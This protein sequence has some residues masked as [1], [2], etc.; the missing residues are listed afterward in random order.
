MFRQII[1]AP[2]QRDFQRILWRDNPQEQVQEYR[3]NTVTYGTGPATFLSVKV[4]LQLA[5]DEGHQYPLAAKAIRDFYVDDI[6]TGMNLRKWTTNDPELLKSLSKDQIEARFLEL[7]E[8]DTIKTLGI[9]WH[10]QGDQFQYRVKP[11]SP[12]KIT[13]RTIL[14]DVASIFDPIGWLA[15]AVLKAKLL[16][17][18]LWKEDIS[19]DSAIPKEIEEDWVEFMDMLPKVQ[20]INIKRFINYAPGAEVQLHG[21]ADSSEKAYGAVVYSRIVCKDSITI[22]LLAAKTRVTPL[23]TKVSLPRLELCAAVLLAE[24][25]NSVKMALQIPD[26]SMHAWSDSQIALSWIAKDPSEW[27]TYI[28]NRVAR[29]LDYTSREMWKHVISEENPADLASRGICPS[30]LK[31]SKI[32]WL[33]PSWLEKAGNNVPPTT[34]V[35]LICIPLGTLQYE[36]KSTHAESSIDALKLDVLTK[37][38]T[39]AKT[40][41]ITAYILRF[42]NN[43][44][45]LGRCSGPLTLSEIKISERTLIKMLQSQHYAQEI[46]RL[47]KKQP[48]Q[49]G[50]KILSLSP[51]LDGRGILRVGGRLQNSELL[52]GTKHPVLIPHKSHLAALILLE[53]HI[54]TYHGGNSLTLNYSRAKYWIPNA[55]TTVK[56]VVSKCITCFRYKRHLTEQVMG[57]LPQDRVTPSPCI[58]TE[59]FMGAFNR[60]ISR[61]GKPVSIYS[62]NGTNLVGAKNLLDKETIRAIRQAMH[63]SLNHIVELGIHWKLNPPSAPHFGGL[64]EAA[65]KSTKKHLKAVLGEASLT[66]EEFST[67]LARVEAALNSRPLAPISDDPSDFE[68]LSPGH[69]LIGRPLLAPPEEEESDA[70]PVKSWKKVAQMHQELWRRWS[71]DYLQQ[72]QHRNK[73]KREREPIRLGQLVLIMDDNLKPQQWPLARVMQLFPGKDGINRVVELKTKTGTKKRP[74]AKVTALPISSPKTEEDEDE[75]P[76]ENEKSGTLRSQEK[77]RSNLHSSRQENQEYKGLNAWKA[78]MLFLM[79]TTVS[80]GTTQGHNFTIVEPSPGLYVENLGSA[81][82]KRGVLRVQFDLPYERAREDRI[83]ITQTFENTSKACREAEEL[84]PD[85]KCTVLL[86][87]LERVKEGALQ[88]IDNVYV[89]TGTLW[90]KLAMANVWLYLASNPEPISVVCQ[91]IREESVITGAGILKIAGGC[92]VEAGTTSLR[93]SI[94]ST[95]RISVSFSKPMDLHQLNLNISRKTMSMARPQPIDAFQPITFDHTPS[96]M[97]ETRSH[98]PLANHPALSAAVAIGTTVL[99]FAAWKIGRHCSSKGSDFPISKKFQKLLAYRAASRR[100]TPDNTTSTGTEMTTATPPSPPPRC[101]HE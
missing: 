54:L 42:I 21:F 36:G 78:L 2:D 22:S 18:R 43:C 33:G 10:P 19:W 7:K 58:S 30:K 75:E 3:L 68:A 81:W 26:A 4:M 24:L 13:R 51:F 72:L 60:F 91:G 38:D 9:G 52:Y 5:E 76:K 41:R 77:A 62:D 83:A 86:T 12:G 61:R 90:K 16:M 40:K 87:H 92:T 59:A 64:W 23:K 66:F 57:N 79:V 70:K 69:F 44:K 95:V 35:S 34:A 29:I 71:R 73:W 101:S 25:L 31:E 56:A 65:V 15:P 48:I 94:E 80:F 100:K 17:Q 93:A 45:S 27:E 14:S 85:I 8:T 89:R 11:R 55:K 28:G 53:A 49:I 6:M 67:I 46:Y 74:I 50:S 63:E 98:M 96:V 1:V 39:F 84:T 88:Q 37:Y 97:V 82:L 99:L 47:K 20:N 32:W